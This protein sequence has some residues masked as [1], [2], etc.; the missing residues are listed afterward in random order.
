MASRMGDSGQVV[1]QN[2][3]P[4]FPERPQHE[5]FLSLA[6]ESLAR[7]CWCHD[8]TMRPSFEAVL[9]ILSRMLW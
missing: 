9:V 2:L 8:P 1:A 3:R 6:Y 4:V 5:S 7:A